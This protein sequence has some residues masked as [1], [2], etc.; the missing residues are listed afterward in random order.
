MNNIARVGIGQSVAT[1]EQWQGKSELRE[2]WQRTL[3]KKLG[4]DEVEIKTRK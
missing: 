4:R 3:D 1:Q 2:I